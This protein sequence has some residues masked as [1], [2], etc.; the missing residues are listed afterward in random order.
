MTLFFE[1]AGQAG[2]FLFTLPLGFALALC[3]DMLSASGK[4][5]PL[6][7]VFVLLGGGAVLG[8]LILL[9]QS[10]EMRMF[11]VLALLLGALIYLGGVGRL[12]ARLKK[13]MVSGRRKNTLKEGKAT[14]AANH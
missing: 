11:H 9:M 5:R 3:L 12:L 4:L 10:E 2:A 14:A 8:W 1:T 13:R 7:D 6:L